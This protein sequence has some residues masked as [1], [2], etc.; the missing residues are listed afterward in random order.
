MNK[1][2]ESEHPTTEI[3]VSFSR[4]VPAESPSNNSSAKFRKGKCDD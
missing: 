1:I 3:P 2:S 4:E